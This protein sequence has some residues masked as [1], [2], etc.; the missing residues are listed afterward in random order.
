MQDSVLDALRAAPNAC[1]A[2]PNIITGGQ[3]TAAQLAALRAAGGGIVLDIR[4]PMEP[5]PFD[6]PAEAK[7]RGLEYVNIPI[8]SGALSDDKLTRILE[9]LRGAG[10]RQVFFHCH[11]GN[12]VGGAMI[13]YLMLDKGVGEEDAIE[14]AMRMGLRS[15]EYVEWAL[16]YVRRHAPPAA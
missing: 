3:P 16:D 7:A 1:R 13:A 12:R 8:S 5:R 6:E 10:E 9:V 2:A 4:D 11:S 15:P 14:Q